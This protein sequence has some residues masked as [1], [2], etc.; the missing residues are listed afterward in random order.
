MK[1]SNLE[2]E[3]RRAVSQKLTKLINDANE[4]P[5]VRDVVLNAL[6]RLD[7]KIN[8]LNSDG[9]GSIAEKYLLRPGKF[10]AFYLKG[11]N[12]FEACKDDGS[13]PLHL[14]NSDW[15]TQIVVNPWLPRAAQDAFYA[16]IEEIVL[17]E[18][19]KTGIDV[20]LALAPSGE[21]PL[22]QIERIQIEGNNLPR[23]GDG[24]AALDKEFEVICDRIQT[25][26]QIFDHDLLGLWTDDRREIGRQLT[27]YIGDQRSPYGVQPPSILLNDAIKPFALYRLGYTWH[28]KPTERLVQHPLVM[29]NGRLALAETRQELTSRPILMEI[30]DI[31]LPRRNTIE[32]ISVWAEIESRHQLLPKT[33][34]I[35]NLPLP[36]L[37][38]HLRENLIM[39][40]EIADETSRHRDKRR[41]REER[42]EE[43]YA[44]YLSMGREQDFRNMVNEMAGSKIAQITDPPTE[45]IRKLMDNV[46]LRTVNAQSEYVHDLNTQVISATRQRIAAARFDQTAR[47]D[48]FRIINMLAISFPRNP[49]LATAYSDDLALYESLKKDTHM[50]VKKLKFTGVDMAAVVRVE[51]DDL[52]SLDP[53]Q[54]S[55]ELNRLVDTKDISI[56]FHSHNTLR[57][58]GIS[59]EVTLVIFRSSKIIAFITLTTA[60]AAEAPFRNDPFRP[61][62]R[63]ASLLDMDEQRKAAAALT[64]DYVVRTRLAKQH[65]AICALLPSQ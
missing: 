6:V 18:M 2:R 1:E 20:A 46:R 49:P 25:I 54:L 56:K 64:E 65:D 55:A 58:G 9:Q 29:Q 23:N 17:D 63:Y 15:D 16:E 38:Y 7:E 50:D 33:D 8:Q 13:D 34:Q 12:A 45:L 62:I 42:I 59:Y 40:C 4:F 43:I 21:S 51:Y 11:G 26:R 22:L 52:I 36:S 57:T 28:F 32:A 41:R 47:I 60:S 44:H 61:S 3:E 37:S 31:T 27:T 14:G 53:V 35:Q 24:T 39:L 48:L 19:R 10:V 5:R 30:L